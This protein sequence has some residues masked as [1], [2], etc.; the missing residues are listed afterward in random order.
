[1]RP[2]SAAGWVFMVGAWAFVLAW[3][4]LALWRVTTLRGAPSEDDGTRR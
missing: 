2:V 3:A 4:A 1:M